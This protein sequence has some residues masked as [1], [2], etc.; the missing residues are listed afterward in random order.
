MQRKIAGLPEQLRK[1]Y[2]LKTMLTSGASILSGGFFFL[3]N[4]VMW[5]LYGI[6]W[7]ASICVYYLLLT[8]IRIIIVWS[9]KDSMHREGSEGANYRRNIYRKT[10]YLLFAMNFALIAPVAIMVRG[11]NR[12]RS[13]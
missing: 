11:G 5:L 12:I 13:G 1:D 8:D 2:L 9:Q 3:Y 7:N 6:A 10:H 4:A